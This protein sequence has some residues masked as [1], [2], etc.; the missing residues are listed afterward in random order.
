MTGREMIFEMN[1]PFHV[2]LGKITDHLLTL[3]LKK[4]HSL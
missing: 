4:N 2:G 3:F 1:I